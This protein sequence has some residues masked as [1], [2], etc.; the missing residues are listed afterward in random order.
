[1]AEGEGG[2]PSQPRGENG[3]S[4]DE[5]TSGL[6]AGQSKSTGEEFLQFSDLAN[7]R[8]GKNELVLVCNY[9][10]CRVIKPGYATLVDREVYNYDSMLFQE[11]EKGR[12]SIYI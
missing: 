5:I 10:R 4:M 3:P 9:C 12:G 6:I 7:P 11:G 1:M 2:S 8:E